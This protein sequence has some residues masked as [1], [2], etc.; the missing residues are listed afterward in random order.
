M[1]SYH[2]QLLEAIV[3]LADENQNEVKEW[4]DNPNKD[5]REELQ[6]IEWAGYLTGND[7]GSYYCNSA[8]AERQVNTSGI[9]FDEGFLNYLRDMDTHLEDIMAKGVETVDVWARCYTL[10]YNVSEEEIKEA[11][12]SGSGY[13]PE[14]EEE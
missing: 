1:N 14:D 5:L 2:E 7:S 10:D 6:R 12:V 11:L 13:S 3:D 9:L 4:L 8:E